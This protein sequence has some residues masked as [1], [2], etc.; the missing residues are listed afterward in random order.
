MS[1]DE[2]GFKGFSH[3]SIP[4]PLSLLLSLHL[5]FESLPFPIESVF[6]SVSSGVAAVDALASALAAVD[7]ATVRGAELG[8]I[9]DDL[10]RKEEERRGRGREEG[11]EERGERE[12]G[13][14][15]GRRGGRRGGGDE[16]R[17]EKM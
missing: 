1:E 11:R 2:G 16:E 8:R 15:D 12:R 7:K 5:S 14:R 3:V 6:H 4:L 9:E 10:T 13:A 17:E